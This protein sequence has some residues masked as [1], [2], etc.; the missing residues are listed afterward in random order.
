MG[1]ENILKR[2]PET[3][4]P[5]IRKRQVQVNQVRPQSFPSVE[6]LNLSKRDHSNA[7]TSNSANASTEPVGPHDDLFKDISDSDESFLSL[8]SLH[9]GGSKE[10]SFENYFTADKLRYS[11]PSP[12]TSVFSMNAC[13]DR[14]AHV[15]YVKPRRYYTN[16]SP[17]LWND[18]PYVRGG[19]SPTYSVIDSNATLNYCA[20]RPPYMSYAASTVSLQQSPPPQY[21]YQSSVAGSVFG[22]NK[23]LISP[24]KF[25]N[26]GGARSFSPYNRYRSH[27]HFDVP[28]SSASQSSVKYGVNVNIPGPTPVVISQQ[29]F[30]NQISRS[31]SQSSGFVSQ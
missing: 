13:S 26:T 30:P 18:Y 20:G 4:E 27:S 17:P 10:Q 21:T 24:P 2:A 23:P 12:P 5:T 28:T 22:G 8:N 29:Y 11:A 3:Y 15:R 31:S 19:L 25:S 6:A 14:N 16:V 1:V 7:S 9:L